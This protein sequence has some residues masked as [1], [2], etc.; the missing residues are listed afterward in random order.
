M[1][2]LDLKDISERYM[3][4]L[5]PTSPEKIIKAGQIAGLKAGDRV[6]DFG[7]GFAEPLILWAERF[8][9]SGVGIDFRPYACE[10]ANKKIAERGLTER[11]SIVC[12]DAAAYTPAPH[13][14]DLASCIGATFIW[15]DFA[16]AVSAMKQA[17]KPQ[18]KLVVGEA[19]WLTDDVPEEFRSAQSE[20]TTEAELLR[21][22]QQEGFDFEYVLH[23]NHDEWDHYEADNWVG[24]L[25]WIEAN[26]EHPERQQVI[27]H[28][29]ESQAEYTRY[30]YKYF[31]W[32]I[33]ILSPVTY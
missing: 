31:G 20:I 16:H 25:R 11:I 7:C 18:G 28:L 32:A 15:S 9:I 2:F 22:A 8:G 10:R 33:Y 30:G 29:H 5:N 24:L 6:I 13:S 26:P 27:D 1:K 12:G 4:L 21:M 3:E 17:V 19:H 14:F 23:S